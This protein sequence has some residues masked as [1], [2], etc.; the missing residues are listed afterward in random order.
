MNELYEQILNAQKLKEETTRNEIS[1][2]EKQI[3]KLQQEQK[4]KRGFNERI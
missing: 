1:E 3:K 4:A 2:I